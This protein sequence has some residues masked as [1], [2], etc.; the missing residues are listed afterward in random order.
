MTRISVNPIS[1]MEIQNRRIALAC[2]AAAS[3]PVPAVTGGSGAPLGRLCGRLGLGGGFRLG[4][5]GIGGVG[6]DLPALR[7]G[8]FLVALVHR[9]LEAAH[10]MAQV[11]A[12]AAA[13][14]L[15]GE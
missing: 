2:L 6:P 1:N 8:L 15:K 11:F 10:G 3:D 13:T 4:K 7:C 5:L 14:I 12:D 9:L